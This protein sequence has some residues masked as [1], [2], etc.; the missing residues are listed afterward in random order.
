MTGAQFG[1]L[2]VI[3]DNGTSDLLCRCECGNVKTVKRY[4]LTRP[5]S[6][7]VKSCGCTARGIRR[8]HIDAGIRFAYAEKKSLARRLGV[9]FELSLDQY[10]QLISQHCHYCN[11]AP[12]LR[13]RRGFQFIG[14]ES[15]DRK[16]PNGDYVTSNVVPCCLSC[17]FRK[18][19]KPYKDFKTQLYIE[20][21]DYLD[22]ILAA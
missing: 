3:K 22:F 21:P 2:T 11:A 18:G 19:A 7:C 16:D 6:R 14:Q 9:R 13:G 4:Y 15:L 20:S 8:R 12:V 17:N 5:K 10:K 1:K